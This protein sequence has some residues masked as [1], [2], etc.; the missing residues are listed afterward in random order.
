MDYEQHYT[1]SNS[2]LL[3]ILVLALVIGNYY[4]HPLDKIFPQNNSINVTPVNNTIIIYRNVTVTVTPTPDGKTYFAGEYENGIRKLGRPFSWLQ[5]NAEGLTSMSGHVKIYDTRYFDSLHIFDPTTYTY[6][7]I[8]PSNDNNQYCFIFVKIYIDNVIGNGAPD[9]WLPNEQHFFLQSKDKV[10]YPIEW[11]K[12][13]RIKELENTWNDN[14]DHRIEYYGVYNSYSRD[15]KYKS[16]AGVYAQDIYWVIGGESNS[17]DGYIV[18]EI[19][20][21]SE[22]DENYVLAELYSFGIPTWK[23]VR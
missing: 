22:P 11:T 12:W 3:I 16:S 7:E 21:G 9:L 1:Y 19:P 4:F 8:K 17:I 20:K 10:Y 6:N 14:N 13:L 2:R 15:L 5:K 23:L 18:Y